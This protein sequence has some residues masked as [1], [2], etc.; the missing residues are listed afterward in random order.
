MSTPA[1]AEMVRYW[2]EVSG[3]KWVAL[4]SVIDRQIEPL[5]RRALARAGLAAGERVL[6]VGCGC[7]ATSLEAARRVAPGGSVLG[8]DL[9]APMLARARERAAAEDVANAE[10][11][12]AD[13][14][15]AALPGPFDA[16]VSRFGVMFF[17]APALAFTNLRRTLR[18]GGRL[19]FVCWQ[20]VNRNPW[21]SVPLAAVASVLPLPTPAAPDAPGPFAFADDGRVRGILAEAGFTDVVVEGV[22]ERLAVGPGD[23]EGTARFLLSMGPAAVVL[24]ESPEA[25][26]R[27]AEVL[28]AVRTAL[29]PHLTPDGVVMPSA[30]WLVSARNPG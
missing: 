29:R 11:L 9:S 25:A 30:C 4:Q 18:T 1:N 5:G 8:L 3:P 10:F 14:Q 20:G 27:E 23:L 2:N 15:T 12:Q 21:M 13:A 6:D 22:E 28:D 19:S 16:V 7:G 24:R 17:D 26:A